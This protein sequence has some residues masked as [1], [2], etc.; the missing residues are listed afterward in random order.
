MHAHADCGP[1]CARF[2]SISTLHFASN[3]HVYTHTHH[4]NIAPIARCMAVCQV[5]V[6]QLP[7]ELCP[8]VLQVATVFP[9]ARP[10][11]VVIRAANIMHAS[12]ALC[13][14]HM[15][16]PNGIST[17]LLSRLTLTLLHA[18]RVLL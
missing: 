1:C 3:S 8:G 11:R 17:A 16:G 15:H 14:L 7:L 5:P 12:Q 4:S 13:S 10:E 2:K 9:R 18:A 6:F